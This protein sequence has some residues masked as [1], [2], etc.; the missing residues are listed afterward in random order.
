MSPAGPLDAVALAV[1]AFVTVALG[2]ILKIALLNVATFPRLRP[3]P[4]A[5]DGAAA[6]SVLIPARDE[7][8]TIGTTVEELLRQDPPPLEVIVLDDGSSDGTA[9]VA[10]AAAGRVGRDR[11]DD[12]AG[13]LRVVI[14]EALPP[15]WAGK[16]WACRRLAAEARAP[17]LLFTDA[18]TR[19]A[20]GALAALEAERRR[21]RAD[22]LTAWPTQT[23][24]TWGER[25]TVPLMALAVLGYLPALLANG[26]AQPLMAA[27]NGQCLLFTREAY[28]AIGGHERVASTVLDDVVFARAVKRSGRR[29]RM[30]DGAGLVGCRMYRGW[31]EARDGFGK[32]ILAGYGGSLAALGAATL[33]HWLVFL[34]PWAWLAFGPLVPPGT[35]VAAGTGGGILAGSW[36]LWPL[37]LAA[38]GIVVRAITAAATRQRVGDA[39]LMPVSVVLMTL[40]ALRAATWARSGGPRWKGRVA[41]AGRR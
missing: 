19:W 32:N 41:P 29:L 17:L 8:A 26:S 31:A 27:A 40:V 20:P 7:A 30:V 1:A 25:L 5:A 21:S 6:I 23:S 34:G 18:D 13:R 16:A 3:A 37:A 11:G 4:D 22:L 10:R 28:D 2:V 33:F 35:G 9:D 14:G 36:P 15:G 12:A 39:L 38:A 24:L